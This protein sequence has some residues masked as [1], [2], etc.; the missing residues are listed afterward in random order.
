MSKGMI[1][2]LPVD[3]VRGL[4]SDLLGKLAGEEGSA[5]LREY[6]KFAVK[7]PCWVK[8]STP[9]INP[10]LLAPVGELFPI[11]ALRRRKTDPFAIKSED[12]ASPFGYRDLGGIR[13]ARRNRPRAIR[14]KAHQLLKPLTFA[15]MVKA[16]GGEEAV[17][18][19]HLFDP[20]QVREL[21]EKQAKGE[22]GPLLV[23]GWANFFF[24]LDESGS[25]AV[26][27]VDWDSAV[28]GWD[29]WAHPVF[30]PLQ[31]LDGCQLLLRT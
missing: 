3:E 13:L 26:V 2:E 16:V 19:K 23:N 10:A 28:G 9:S 5:F 4:V 21:V 30:S 6:K 14:V 22:A 27:G 29:V 20:L 8:T 12:K 31:W 1:G 24:V 15:E 18:D 25:L 17:R 7:Q 11:P